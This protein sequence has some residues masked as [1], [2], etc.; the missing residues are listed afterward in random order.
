MKQFCVGPELDLRMR[1]VRCYIFSVL[2]YGSEG[3]ILLL[4]AGCL[5]DVVL[6]RIHKPLDILVTIK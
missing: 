5:C 4:E 1:M 2:L 3:L 6:A